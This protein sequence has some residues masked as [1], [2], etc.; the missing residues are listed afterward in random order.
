MKS[1][2]NRETVYL[3]GADRGA[4]YK[5][6][7][8]VRGCVASFIQNMLPAGCEVAMDRLLTDAHRLGDDIVGAPTINF[9]RGWGVN[10]ALRI[11]HS[12]YTDVLKTTDG[13]LFIHHQFNVTVGWSAT[14]RTIAQSLASITLYRE[15][16]EFAALLEHAMSGVIGEILYMKG[17][18]AR[19]TYNDDRKEEI[20]VSGWDE[21]E[22]RDNA[23]SPDVARVDILCQVP[24]WEGTATWRSGESRRVVGF[25]KNK[26]TAMEYIMEHTFTSEERDRTAASGPVFMELKCKD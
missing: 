5:P 25:G 1:Q 20:I 23:H 17:Y 21:D 26:K 14:D 2:P 8:E 15:V 24:R 4:S 6:L 16:T 3:E 10:V 19:V 9:D 11:Q 18:E 7:T 12:K 22:A 13:D